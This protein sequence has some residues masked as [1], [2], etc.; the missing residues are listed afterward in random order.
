MS[1]EKTPTRKHRHPGTG[2]LKALA[3]PKG[4]GADPQAVSDIRALLGYRTPLRDELIEYLHLIQDTH[5]HIS[6]Q[7]LAALAEVMDLS[8][9]EV[10]ETA[11]F[12]AHFDVVG[13]DETPPPELTIRVC[14]SLTCQISGAADLK[15]L[16]DERVDDSIRVVTA[17]C[18][19]RCDR[20]P[21]V[22]VGNNHLTAADCETILRTTDAGEREAV[23]AGY[24]DLD[25]YARGNGYGLYQQCAK[26]KYKPEDIMAILEKAGL[27]GL[28]GAGFPAATKWKFVRAEKGPRYLVVN[29]DEGEPGTFKDRHYLESDPHRFLEG[30]L[31]AAWAVQADDIY[32]YLRDEYPHIKKILEKEIER[33]RK[34]NL[35]SPVF[36]LR[37]GAGAYICGEESA[38]LES[39]EGKRGLARAKPPLPAH[40]GAFGQ[41]TVVNNVLTLAAKG[42]VSYSVS[43][44]TAATLLSPLTVPIALWVTLGSSVALDPLKVSLDLL[45]LVVGPVVAGHLICR[46]FKQIEALM[47]IIAPAAANLTILAIIAVIVGVNRGRLGNVT[48]YVLVG[49]LIVNLLG[50]VAGYCGGRLL[51]LPEAMRRALTLEVGMQNAGLGTVLVIEM[52]PKYPEAAIPTAAYTFGCMLTGTMLAHFWSRKPTASMEAS[53][54]T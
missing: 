43:L 47:R 9:A 21:V 35:T 36:H 34:R 32:I 50:Y 41:P 25:D 15:A 14:D 18:M 4:R 12:Y 27:R 16:L 29:A 53:D 22:A 45:T 5:H 46:Y 28:G 52:F 10:F 23:V 3:H 24:I 8:M 13:D 19:G 44:T 37:R 6:A 42:N 1:L 31:I 51:R 7:N 33:L 48:P 30:A 38:L 39:L 17:P 11:T 26:G 54:A 49:L 40:A 2:K 20:A